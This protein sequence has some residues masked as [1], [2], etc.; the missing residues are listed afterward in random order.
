MK[1]SYRI[2][3]TL[4]PEQGELFKEFMK[5]RKITKT[6]LVKRAIGLYLSLQ[7]NKYRINEKAYPV[8][9][10][11]FYK[12]QKI[13]S[14]KDYERR[15]EKIVM[16]LEKKYS[17]DEFRE[18]KKFFNNMNKENKVFKRKG[19]SGRPKITNPRGRPK[20]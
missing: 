11:F 19:K 4:S 9:T 20:L 5:K 3:A 16:K 7:N 15:T 14:S 18:F 1:N 8:V 10:E 12:I 2:S 6:Q 17:K 13:V